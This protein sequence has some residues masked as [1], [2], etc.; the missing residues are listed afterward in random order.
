M[1]LAQA[2]I[3]ATPVPA[4]AAL[5]GFFRIMALWDVSPE[6]ARILL[7]SPS[8]S[9]YYAW[10]RGESGRLSNDTL[11]RIGYVAG[12]FK[13]LQLLYADDR[14]SDGWIKRPNRS[15]GGQTPIARMKAG[16]MTDL[17]AVRSYLDAARAPWS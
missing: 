3:D 8:Q 6:E 10:R 4:A 16:D 2:S 9:A 14:L 11:R 15:F 1:S 17:A 7:G 13:A 12:I 5:V